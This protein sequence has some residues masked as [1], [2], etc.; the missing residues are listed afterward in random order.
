[1]S[2]PLPKF[3]GKTSSIFRNLG[4]L[5]SG[6]PWLEKKRATRP[7]GSARM[8]NSILLIVQWWAI[9][10]Y[11]LFGSKPGKSRSL[12]RQLFDENRRA[13]AARPWP[14]V[15]RGGGEKYKG[16]SLPPAVCTLIISRLQMMGPPFHDQAGFVTRFGTLI[17][18][19]GVTGEKEKEQIKKKKNRKKKKRRK[20]DSQKKG[21]TREAN[22]R[23]GGERLRFRSFA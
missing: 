6:G 17:R 3:L 8:L 2:P 1:L 21:R 5:A 4:E 9:L 14:K 10:T 16:R 23:S 11:R 18:Q 7:P 12:D 15:G 19:R 22:K 13:W 20:K